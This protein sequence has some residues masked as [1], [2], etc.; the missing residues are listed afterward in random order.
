MLRHLDVAHDDAL[1][2][3]RLAS[4]VL[5][6]DGSLRASPELLA[7]NTLGQEALWPHSISGDLPILLVRVGDESP[8]PLIRQILEAQEYWRLKGLSADIVI[9]NEHPV[10]YVDETHQQIGTLLEAGPW[11]AWKGRPGGVYLLRA[12]QLSERDVWLLIAVARAVL[13]GDRGTLANQLDRPFAAVDAREAALQSQPRAEAAAAL[14]EGATQAEAPPMVL[15]N[16]IGGFAADG[17]EYTMVLD[18]DRETPLPWVN[19]IANPSFGTIV[20]ASGSAFT[21]ALNS[22]ENRLTPFWNDPITDP[23]AEAL[24]VRDVETGEL[25][26]DAGSDAPHISE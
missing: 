4:R 21:W 6:L 16:G 1:Q 7:K 10:S 5:Y 20:S 23:T 2:Y 24:F 18:G 12:D 13:H 26:P 8:L 9:L 3:E 19:V 22:R 17:R 25:V 11:R 14:D 15:F